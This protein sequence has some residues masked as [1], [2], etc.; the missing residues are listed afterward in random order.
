VRRTIDERLAILAADAQLEPGLAEVHSVRAAN[1][2]S[3]MSVP[4]WNESQVIGV[5]YLD[6][7]R[8][9]PL[10]TSDLDVLQALSAYAAVA[11]EQARLTARVLEKRGIASG[12]SASLRRRREQSSSS[13]GQRNTLPRRRTRRHDSLRRHRGLHHHVGEDAAVGGR[14]HAQPVLRGHVR[15]GVR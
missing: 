12:C 10:A 1:V 14:P 5:L 2:R 7:P 15:R 8:S 11:I 6:S 9:A 13:R 4:L 3:F